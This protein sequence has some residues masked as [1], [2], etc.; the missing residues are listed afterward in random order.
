MTEAIGI[1]LD[2]DFLKTIDKI[3]KE[4]SMDRSVI[5]RKLL[6]IGFIDFIKQKVKEKYI[7]GENIPPYKSLP[8]QPNNTK[9][10]SRWL[11]RLYSN[12]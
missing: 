9:P 12:Q 5:L 4:E 3:S 1:R 7:Q 6:K 2:E 8:P 10:L 11:V